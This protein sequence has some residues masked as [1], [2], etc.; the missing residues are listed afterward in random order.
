MNSTLLLVLFQQIVYVNEC[1][2]FLAISELLSQRLLKV[3]NSKYIIFNS[4]VL[5]NLVSLA[6]LAFELQIER[7]LIVV[8]VDV[9]A[10]EVRQLQIL[11][12][13]NL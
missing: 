11:N 5:V 3:F 6:K 4:V 9:P 1:Q 7:F 8:E 2:V 13:V 12:V 10:V